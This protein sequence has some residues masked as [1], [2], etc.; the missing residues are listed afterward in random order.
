M[1]T[2]CETRKAK[3]RRKRSMNEMESS[4]V[5]YKLN[6]ICFTIQ[7]ALQ[8]TAHPTAWLPQKGT[9]AL[10][11]HKQNVIWI[12]FFGALHQQIPPS[13]P[14]SLTRLE[15]HPW[16]SISHRQKQ[17]QWM[18][19]FDISPLHV[20]VIIWV[21]MRWLMNVFRIRCAFITWRHRLIIHPLCSQHSSFSDFADRQQVTEDSGFGNMME[22][23]ANQTQQNRVRKPNNNWWRVGEGKGTQKINQKL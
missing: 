16:K 23:V 20:F 11:M 19:A 2:E 6:F 17:K 14:R 13:R 3:G 10:K 18:T 8:P 12:H 4:R 1:I 9:S 15:T 22:M 21:W 7:H 5:V